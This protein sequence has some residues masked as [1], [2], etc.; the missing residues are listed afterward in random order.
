[1]TRATLQVDEDGALGLAAA[2]AAIRGIRRFRGG[3]LKL[4]EVGEA[5]AEQGR[6]TD[7][8]QVP[9]RDAVTRITSWLSGDHEHGLSP[10]CGLAVL[11]GR[12]TRPLSAREGGGGRHESAA[13]GRRI[14]F[15]TF[16]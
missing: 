12:K 13:Y 7:T 3:F 15:I 4:E 10:L 11:A 9:P 2:R 5:D 8:E 14:S 1:M 16:T 6:A